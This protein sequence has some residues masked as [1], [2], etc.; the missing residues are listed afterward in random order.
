MLSWT[1]KLQTFVTRAI[2]NVQCLN[3]M[4]KNR[5]YSPHFAYII[6]HWLGSSKLNYLNSFDGQTHIIWF[7][8]EIITL[9]MLALS[10]EKY[11]LNTPSQGKLNGIISILNEKPLQPFPIYW[12]TKI[13]FFKINK[14]ASNIVDSFRIAFQ[15]HQLTIVFL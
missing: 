1:S 5:Q 13:I 2:M 7:Q 12:I 3:H 4:T 11:L 9:L 8:N 14:I 6:T 15:L 10:I